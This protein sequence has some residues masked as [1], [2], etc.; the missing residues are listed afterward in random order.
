MPEPARLDFQPREL[1]AS[2]SIAFVSAA[3]AKAVA[4]MRAGLTARPRVSDAPL[5]ISQAHAG[6]LLAKLALLE[7]GELGQA[8]LDFV[9]NPVAVT[10]SRGRVVDV[11]AVVH[12]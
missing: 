8:G 6:I 12:A 10:V 3:P 7:L 11:D 9:R 5:Q 1:L 4:V 2:P